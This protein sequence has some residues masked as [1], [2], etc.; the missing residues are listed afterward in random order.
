[1]FC[2]QNSGSHTFGSSLNS[3]ELL[4]THMLYSGY[5][6]YTFAGILFMWCLF[7]K[8][9]MHSFA[10]VLRTPMTLASGESPMFPLVVHQPASPSIW[11]AVQSLRWGLSTNPGVIMWCVCGNSWR[12]DVCRVC[13]CYRGGI[14]VMDVIWRIWFEEW[15]FTFSEMNKGTTSETGKYL[16]RDANVCWRCAQ[17]LFIDTCG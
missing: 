12:D 9:H 16:F 3:V 2:S 13:E 14:M 17:Y 5:V 11:P 4:P 15:W 8:K 10:V 1:M 7:V 6:I